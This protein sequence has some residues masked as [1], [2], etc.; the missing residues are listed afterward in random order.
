MMGFMTADVFHMIYTNYSYYF[1]CQTG[2]EYQHP[3][4][5]PFQHDERIRDD[6]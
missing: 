5:F 3:P 6:T 2:Y 1:I 4:P